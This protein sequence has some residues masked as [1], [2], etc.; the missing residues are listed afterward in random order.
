MFFWWVVQKFTR[1]E[2]VFLKV[3]DTLLIYIQNYCGR[4]VLKNPPKEQQARKLSGKRTVIIKKSGEQL[5]IYKHG[6]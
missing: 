6:K 2:C 3:A 1:K 5:K 4:E